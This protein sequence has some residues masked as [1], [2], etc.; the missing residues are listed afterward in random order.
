MGDLTENFSRHEFGCKC[1]CGFDKIDPRVVVMCQ[2]IRD[3]MGEP[4]RINSACRCEKRNAEAEGVKN[5][6]HTQGMAADLSCASGSKNLYTII[7][8]LYLG[9]KLNDLEY[10]K[11]YVGKNFVHIDCGRKRSTR[12]VE[13]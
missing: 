6:Y 10:C 2:K 13:G 12:F 11:R 5:S 1:G 4:V 8:A 7:K 9:G 3:A